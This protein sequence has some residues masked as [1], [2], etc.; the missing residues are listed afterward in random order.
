M[1]KIQLLKSGDKKFVIK[2]TIDVGRAGQMEFLSVYPNSMSQN[3]AEARL[4]RLSEMYGYERAH[5]P[6]IDASED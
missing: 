5:L 3:E 4:F 1:N 6:Y 2:L